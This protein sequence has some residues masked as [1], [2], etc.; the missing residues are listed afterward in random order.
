MCHSLISL[1]LEDNKI[2]DDENISYLS[3]LEKLRKLNLNGNKIQENP[4]YQ[5]LIAKYLPQLEQDE[6]F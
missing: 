5:N 6:N 3:G 1:N 4:K 2:E